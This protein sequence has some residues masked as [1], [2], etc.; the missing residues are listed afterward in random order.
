MPLHLA[1]NRDEQ[2]HHYLYLLKQLNDLYPY[3]EYVVLKPELGETNE[4]LLIA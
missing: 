3:S 1:S 2:K 4:K